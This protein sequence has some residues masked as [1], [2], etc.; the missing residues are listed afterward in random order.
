[1]NTQFTVDYFLDK[2]EKI[3]E[4]NWITNKWNVGDACCANGHCGVRSALYVRGTD[5]SR[6]LAKLF[7][8]IPASNI[9]GDKFLAYHWQRVSQVNDGLIKEYQQPTAK[10]R[11]LAALRDIKKLNS[12]QEAQECDATNDHQG[13]EVG[14]KKYVVVKVSESIYDQVKELV[15]S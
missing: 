14:T 6:A 3:P 8:I 12:G 10:Q 1:M 9:N 5:E 2:F 13:T 7:E 11:I 15:M 4:D